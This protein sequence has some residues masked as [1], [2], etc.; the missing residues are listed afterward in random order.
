[1]AQ[2]AVE[3]IG[4]TVATGSH[5][6]DRSRTNPL[7]IAAH[8]TPF[9]GAPFAHRLPGGGN[10]ARQRLHL[11]VECQLIGLR[12]RVAFLITEPR[13][14]R[15]LSPWAIRSRPGR[16]RRPN[17]S[18]R[19]FSATENS[20]NCSKPPSWR[21]V[22]QRATSAAKRSSSACDDCGECDTFAV[23]GRIL[24]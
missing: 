23:I 6:P 7:G 19:L 21:Y 12:Q 22:C 13:Q 18:E 11:A 8:D 14:R 10:G 3:M 2:L 4:Q 20:T 1:M 24:F 17:C 5:Q 16:R 15:I 9:L